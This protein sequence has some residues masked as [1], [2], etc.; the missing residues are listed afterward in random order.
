MSS[1]LLGEGKFEG[2]L[3]SGFV[4]KD[5]LDQ[6]WK[7]VARE[8][9]QGTIEETGNQLGVNVGTME[10]DERVNIDDRL[11]LVENIQRRILQNSSVTDEKLAED[12]AR[13]W[14]S[15]QMVA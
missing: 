7:N 2:D 8:T 4:Y 9:A 10:A 3:V 11:E 12:I 5:G 6:F 14:V 13:R 1:K 15:G